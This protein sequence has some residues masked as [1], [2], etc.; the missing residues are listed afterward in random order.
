MPA[1]ILGHDNICTQLLQQ[2]QRCS[3]LLQ[4]RQ[5]ALCYAFAAAAGS[6]SVRSSRGYCGSVASAAWRKGRV[7]GHSWTGGGTGIELHPGEERSAV[8]VW[9]LTA[10]FATCTLCNEL[11][12]TPVSRLLWWG[13]AWNAITKRG[14]RCNTGA[15]LDISSDSQPHAAVVEMSEMVR[16]GCVTA[17][18]KD[19]VSDILLLQYATYVHMHSSGSLGSSCALRSARQVQL[20]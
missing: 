16:V 18:V 14:C 1:M 17:W 15:M 11:C 12:R 7:E 3:S 8:H 19:T 20:A 4:A 13:G 9:D 5:A 6:T 2:S 10:C